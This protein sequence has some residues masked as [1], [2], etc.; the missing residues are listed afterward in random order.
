MDKVVATKTVVLDYG[1]V[2]KCILHINKGQRWY[3]VAK[4]D[5]EQRRNYYVIER[6]NVFLELHEQD[7]NNLF[8]PS[9]R[10]T[11]WE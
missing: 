2:R 6:D 3:V 9:M 1:M 8:K 4:P 10:G 5:V 7:F 11:K